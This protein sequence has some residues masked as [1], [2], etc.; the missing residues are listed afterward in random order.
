MTLSSCFYYLL[1]KSY[2]INIANLVFFPETCNCIANWINMIQ[3]TKFNIYILIY[4]VKICRMILTHYTA[5]LL[6]LTSYTI[7]CH[8]YCHCYYPGVDHGISYQKEL[9][10]WQTRNLVLSCN[11]I[12]Q[13][14]MRGISRDNDVSKLTM[15]YKL[16]KMESLKQ[17]DLISWNVVNTKYHLVLRYKRI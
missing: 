16:Y 3:I 12:L 5:K 17:L 2:T 6:E 7:L 11:R 8:P 9:F 10:L 4:I 15:L 13:Q 14:T 1:E